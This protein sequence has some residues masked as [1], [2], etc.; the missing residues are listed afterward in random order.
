MMKYSK[1][2]V[3]PKNNHLIIFPGARKQKRANEATDKHIK[4]KPPQ[5]LYNKYPHPK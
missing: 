1:Q 4:R 3:R 5:A 2:E